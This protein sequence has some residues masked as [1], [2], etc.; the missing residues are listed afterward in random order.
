MTGGQVVD[1]PIRV[2]TKG[3][4]LDAAQADADPADF[5]VLVQGEADT[6]SERFAPAGARA[7]DEV[8]LV[9]VFGAVRE[10]GLV[11]T[12]QASGAGTALAI[13]SVDAEGLASTLAQASSPTRATG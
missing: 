5:A 8:G 3:A 6:D 2:D 1:L 4:V 12:V 13:V 7:L 11:V 10:V 9:G